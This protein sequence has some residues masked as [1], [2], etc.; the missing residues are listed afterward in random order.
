[1]P[2]NHVLF[3]WLVKHASEVLFRFAKGDD[4]KT[5]YQRIKGR[6]FNKAIVEWAE[7]VQYQKL[8]TAGENKSEFRWEKGIYLGHLDVTGEL[9]IGT[10][11]G[12]VKAR[13]MRRY[14]DPAVSWDVEF[15]FGIKGTPWQPVPGSDRE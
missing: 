4:G 14:A 1:M 6:P 11:L 9:R 3:A 2:G 10:E 15:I 8:G 12:V 5:A 13:D 7:V